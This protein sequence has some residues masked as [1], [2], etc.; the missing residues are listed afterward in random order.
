MNLKKPRLL[1]K[2][3]Q[4]KQSERSPYP[5]LEQTSQGREI[6]LG[7]WS[8]RVFSSMNLSKQSL[9]PAG[10]KTRNSSLINVVENWQQKFEWHAT[11]SLSKLRY[12]QNVIMNYT[13]NS[14]K[15]GRISIIF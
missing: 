11:G 4:E 7:P 8:L 5:I 2:D 14:K 6:I 9:K 13:I 12:R 3:L 15:R 10:L 1:K